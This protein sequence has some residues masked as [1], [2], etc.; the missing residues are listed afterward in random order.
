[1]LLSIN[2]KDPVIFFVILSGA[3]A[4]AQIFY[5]LQINKL[6]ALISAVLLVSTLIFALFYLSVKN[7][8]LL[9]LLILITNYITG[10]SGRELRELFPVLFFFSF[11]LIRPNYI[12]KPR[13][14]PI[15]FILYALLLLKVIF[16]NFEFLDATKTTTFIRRWEL[17][18][19]LICFLLGY[20]LS[21][22]VD[23]WKFNK[24]F[25]YFN[26]LVL[27]ISA[28]MFIL[29]IPEMPLFNTF[30]WM[31][32]PFDKRMG[33][34]SGAGANCILLLVCN[35]EVLSGRFWRVGI[36]VLS[37]FG[38]IAGG[39]RSN[40]VWVVL[41]YLAYL[42][43]IKK[44]KLL[45]VIF[46]ALAIFIAQ[47]GKVVI[48]T[49]SL[50][51]KYQRVFN[52]IN[53]K[54]LTAAFESMGHD[55][56]L[57]ALK[58]FA[59]TGADWSSFTRLYMWNTAIMGM[60]E[61]PIFGYGVQ[62]PFAGRDKAS[63][64]LVNHPATIQEIALAGTLHNSFFSLAYIAGVPTAVF[65]ILFMLIGFIKA[66]RLT[67][68][69]NGSAYNYSFIFIFI[70]CINAITGDVHL[71]SI[72][73]FFTGLIFNHYSILYKRID[74]KKKFRKPLAQEETMVESNLQRQRTYHAI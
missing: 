73:M 19:S 15:I 23:I 32:I 12:L 14:L 35:K 25:F 22:E 20:Y 66:K 8:F 51:E 27:G 44:K 64:D 18:T 69:K 29:D 10:I 11:I 6:L 3:F 57:E 17:F 60:A 36:Y 67:T 70:S 56:E 33:I 41:G 46:I 49:N 7:A 38:I 13:P 71:S 4:F 43:V 50:P 62:N 21:K 53:I 5:Y 31:K 72:F 52:I 9:I 37:L 45:V 26:L 54:M 61:K 24:I 74:R 34:L 65:F 63:L 58:E 1:M 59:V 68:I 2:K 48:N 55:K 16:Q 30:S 28:M 47:T 39:G 42:F 40:L